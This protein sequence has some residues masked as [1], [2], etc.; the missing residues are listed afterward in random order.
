MNIASAVLLR[1]LEDATTPSPAAGGS[2][3]RATLRDAT[4]ARVWLTG[5]TH[6]FA[7][8]CD[9]AGVDPKAA[10]EQMLLLASAGWQ[11]EEVDRIRRVIHPR[12][13]GESFGA[14]L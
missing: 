12:P 14:A 2:C 6:D 11:G 10:H 9:R 8:V 3:S 5:W 13:G 1:A 4:A 7:E